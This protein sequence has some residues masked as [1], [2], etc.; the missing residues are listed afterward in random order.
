MN[1]FK[2]MMGATALAVAAVV[3][4]A[5]NK[6]KTVQHET[7][8]SQQETVDPNDLTLADIVEVIS[9]ADGKTFFENHPIKDYTT[10]CEMVL[11]GCGFSEKEAG[12]PFVIS[13]ELR[14]LNGNCNPNAPGACLVVRKKNNSFE[15]ANAMGYFENGKL[16]IV[17][18]LEEN[19]FTADGYLVIGAP[20]EI[21]NDSIVI[22]EG[23][24]EAYFDEEL[25]AYIA[26]AVDYY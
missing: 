8:N 26:V 20:I 16:V 24:Y 21:Q 11:N 23:I 5:C 22:Q 10:V 14:L 7:L 19:G 17:P 18:D 4:I 25:G 1:K 15:Q 12:L 13:W 2:I 3:I 9:W 6:E